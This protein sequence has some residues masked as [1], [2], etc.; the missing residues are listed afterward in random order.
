MNKLLEEPHGRHM[1]LDESYGMRKLLAEPHGQDMS[2]DEPFSMRNLLEETHCVCN[3]NFVG[4]CFQDA[5]QCRTY[6]YEAYSESKYRCKKKSSKVY[7][8]ISLLSDSTFFKLFFHIFAAIIA[9]LIVA[10]HKFLC[11]LLI[12]R[13]RR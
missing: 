12:E 7:Y 4:H 2:L 11:T 3:F 6:K 10:R 1:L 8:K 5:Q 13:G 9:V